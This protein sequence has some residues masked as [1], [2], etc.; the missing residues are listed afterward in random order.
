MMIFR[1]PI[2]AVRLCMESGRNNQI[3]IGVRTRQIQPGSSKSDVQHT[4]GRY[5]Q[6]SSSLSLWSEN[7][8][9]DD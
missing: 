3:E 7:R 4:V 6:V 5:L 1:K 8:S 9:V 2:I